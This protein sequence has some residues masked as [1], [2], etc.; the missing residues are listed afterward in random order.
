MASD[1]HTDVLKNVT[2]AIPLLRAAEDAQSPKAETPLTVPYITHRNPPARAE[3]NQ[4][5]EGDTDSGKQRSTDLLVSVVPF[6]M[7]SGADWSI[8][9]PRVG[10]CN[11]R[12]RSHRTSRFDRVTA[13][14][15][16]DRHTT[17]IRYQGA[18]VALAFIVVLVIPESAS[19]IVSHRHLSTMNSK[20]TLD[21]PTQSITTQL[22][23]I[24]GMMT[25]GNFFP[26]LLM[27]QSH[28]QTST[29]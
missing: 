7:A 9:N 27:S 17:Q 4:M 16:V 11:L 12:L 2:P 22:R 24:V 14:G 26:N 13:P 3:R 21:H 19:N 6:A 23:R 1:K 15:F 18:F 20:V 28:I 8:V 29:L 5:L 25:V 10:R